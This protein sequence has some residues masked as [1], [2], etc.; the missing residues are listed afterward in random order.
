M[1]YLCLFN[2]LAGNGKG[3]MAAEELMPLMKGDNLEFCDLTKIKDYKEFFEKA[4][5]TPLILC[6]G[7]GT[8]NHFIN[9]T[10]GIEL[11]SSVF[12]YATGSGNDFLNDVGKKKGD[13]PFKIN[14]Y[15]K[16]PKG[17]GKRKNLSLYKRYRIRY[18]R[19][20]L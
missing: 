18:R 20:L 17:H 8:L 3:A 7:D 6:G 1:K 19:I 9:D 14:K 12:Y 10:D 13:R 5:D 4:G 11:P 15:L 2:P 16:S